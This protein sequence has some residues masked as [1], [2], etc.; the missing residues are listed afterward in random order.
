M[1]RGY[2]SG[3]YVNGIDAKHRLSV[4]A[5]L[6]ETVE[7]RSATKAIVLAA[8]EHA[9][10]LMGFDVTHFERI[11]AD[12]SARFAG[13]FGPGRSM[14]ARDLFGMADTLK[15]DDSG[16]IILTPILLELGELKGD[17]LFLGAG[18]YFELWSP[19]AML[20]RE[21]Q[22]PRLLKVVRALVAQRGGA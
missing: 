21:G 4:P 8:A 15:Y 10:C 1:I 6:R 17:A 9:P 12:L 14:A 3:A 7:T 13:D 16:R 2:F 20:A 22:D 19:A 18:D 5:P 11:Q